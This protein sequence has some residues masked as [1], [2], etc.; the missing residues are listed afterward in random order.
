MKGSNILI[1]ALYIKPVCQACDHS[2]AGHL[3]VHIWLKSSFI[4][5]N[6]E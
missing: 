1:C 4:Q 6:Y 5:S 3:P 2:A